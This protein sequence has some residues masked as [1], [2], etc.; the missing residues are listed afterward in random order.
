MFPIRLSRLIPLVATIVLAFG[1]SQ[2][3]LAYSAAPNTLLREAYGTL[4]K[5][6][7]DYKGHRVEAIKQILL[8][9]EE[10][11]E[12]TH[13]RRHAVTPVHHSVKRSSGKEKES[14]AASDSR[15]RTAEGLLQE[16]SNEASGKKLQ[17]INNALAQL[18]IA[19]SVH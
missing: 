8:A 9:M 17:H 19:L 11:T 13:G 15:L 12:K 16:A 4:A 7:H 5:A 6:D 14:Q 1:V 10:S 3:V 18:R 2:R